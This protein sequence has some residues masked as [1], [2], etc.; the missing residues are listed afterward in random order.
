MKYLCT[1]D[2]GNDDNKNNGLHPKSNVDWLYLLRN[3]GGGGLIGV[4]NIVE[5]PIFG[6]RNYVRKSNERLLIAARTIKGDEDRQTPPPR[7]KLTLPW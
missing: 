7:L 6:L 5:T 4:Q 1:K 3:E 2:T